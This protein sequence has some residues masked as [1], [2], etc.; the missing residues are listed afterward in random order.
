MYSSKVTEVLENTLSFLNAFI[1]T[2]SKNIREYVEL[3]ETAYSPKHGFAKCE[4]HG[5]IHVF[6]IN[7]ARRIVDAGSSDAH[8]IV[9]IVYKNKTIDHAEQTFAREF[10]QAYGQKL[11]TPIFQRSKEI[12]VIC[13]E[14][15]QSSP[16]AHAAMMARTAEKELSRQLNG[17]SKKETEPVETSSKVVIKVE[18][19]TTSTKKGRKS[20]YKDRLGLPAGSAK[21]SHTTLDE[22]TLL[23]FY[24]CFR[25]A[26]HITEKHAWTEAKRNHKTELDNINVYICVHCT[27][28]HVGHLSSV[29]GLARTV[30]NARKH[31]R[32]HPSDADKFAKEKGWV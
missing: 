24:T 22:F 15:V 7:E 19:T 9:S 2:Q 1:C 5:V 21:V 17:T 14:T 3:G 11:F 18:I 31:W 16:I 13:R 28:Y 29:D 20:R 23:E 12:A 32:T 10:I 6:D 30:K 8:K 25:K 4:K 27:G 26:S